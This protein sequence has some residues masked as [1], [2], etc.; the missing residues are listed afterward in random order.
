MGQRERQL[1]GGGGRDFKVVINLWFFPFPVTV[2]ALSNSGL[3]ESSS[4]ITINKLQ[5]RQTQTTVPQDTA[6][7]LADSE[8][9]NSQ[10]CRNRKECPG[11]VEGHK[12]GINVFTSPYF[13][14]TLITMDA[15][16]HPKIGL[17]PRYQEV[18]GPLEFCLL[19]L[20]WSA[21]RPQLFRHV[22]H[23]VAYWWGTT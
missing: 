22:G 10:R 5:F 16:Q 12:P 18:G 8:L 2:L 20:W 17:H 14:I 23:S 19:V 13:V 1:K 15:F 7:S 4:F 6:C 9:M 3:K 11:L 21:G